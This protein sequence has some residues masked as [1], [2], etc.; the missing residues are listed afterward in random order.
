MEILWI[1]F[2]HVKHLMDNTTLACHVY[3]NKSCK[4]L[5][6]TCCDVQFEDGI[7]QT[8][9]RK[10]LNSTHGGEWNAKGKFKGFYDESFM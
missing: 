7:E 5:T 2:D 8:L 6:I 1:M 3:D 9:F 4:I 10:N